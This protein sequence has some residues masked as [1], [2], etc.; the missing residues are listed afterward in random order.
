[1]AKQSANVFRNKFRLSQCI[2]KFLNVSLDYEDIEAF[3]K[4]KLF[5]NLSNSN[6]K[7]IGGFVGN[8]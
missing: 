4:M 8:I 5:S 7:K 3:S 6:Q 2:S 1:M